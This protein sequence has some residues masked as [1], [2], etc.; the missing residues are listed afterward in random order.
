M[1]KFHFVRMSDQCVVLREKETCAFRWFF[2]VFKDFFFVIF[3]LINII[4]I[5][6][7]SDLISIS[8]NFHAVF[9]LLHSQSSLNT[10]VML[11]TLICFPLAQSFFGQIVLFF[12]VIVFILIHFLWPLL[13]YLC[14]VISPVSLINAGF[15]WLFFLL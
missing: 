3:H 14:I 11:S 2:G 13:I 4:A 8:F 7:W 1:F 9:F 15:K 5:M 12:S 10:H 6:K